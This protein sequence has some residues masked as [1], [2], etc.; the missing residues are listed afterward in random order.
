MM[1][2]VNSVF[3][4]GNVGK[5]PEIKTMPSGDKVANLAVATSEKWKDKDGNKQERTDWHTVSVFGPS[6]GFV[7]RYISKGTSVAVQGKIRTEKYNDKYYTK[8]LVD[9]GG[10]IQVLS[11]WKESG[12]TGSRQVNDD[13]PF[14]DSIPF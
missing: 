7:E 5:D 10:N 11:G 12:N 4:I 2:S 1:A 13:D 6:V 8:I 3:L 14:S 9:R